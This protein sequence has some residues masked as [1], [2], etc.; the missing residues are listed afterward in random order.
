MVKSS[1]SW[2]VSENR[3]DSILNSDRYKFLANLQSELY[4]DTINFF[5][6]E[7]YEYQLLPLTTG[8]ISSPMGLGSDSLPVKVNIQGVETYLSDSMQF[9]LELACR[10]N[11][12]NNFYISPSF[13]GEPADKRHLCQ[14]F[15]VEAEIV[16]GIDDVIEVIEKYLFYLTN[17]L[18]RKFQ[19]EI[20]E[21]C[22]NTEH[23]EKFLLLNKIPRCSFEEAVLILKNNP[24]KELIIDKGSYRTISSAG[25]RELMKHFGGFVWLTNFDH[26]SVPFYQKFTDKNKNC[27]ENADLLIGIGE[28][29]GSGERHTTSGEVKEA[30]KI[31]HVSAEPYEWYVE[32]KNMVRLHTS[33]FGMGVER[34]LLWLLN[35]DDIRDMQLLPR[36]NGIKSDF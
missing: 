21:S 18:Y 14:F 19:K 29:V 16:G 13:R 20:F 36:F 2:F 6:G 12:K 30:L 35:H 15:H 26:L 3:F 22:G 9:Y 34:Y 31:H 17:H 11:K 33:G 1:K 24:Q 27:A 4:K 10:I 25:E 8:S 23:I 5:F 7:G 28:T 32:M